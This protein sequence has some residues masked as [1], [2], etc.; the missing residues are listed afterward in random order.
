[1]D[2]YEIHITLD[3]EMP[4]VDQGFSTEPDELKKMI[5]QINS[6]RSKYLKS[7]NI[8]LDQSCLGSGV[9]KTLECEEYV[10]KF[11]FK[12]IFTTKNNGKQMIQ[13]LVIKV[14]VSDK[15]FK[16]E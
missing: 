9:R 12:S 11:A 1:M 7:E 10:R 4:G 2:L 3:R 15:G 5:H 8:N 16:P 14:L 13:V 6:V